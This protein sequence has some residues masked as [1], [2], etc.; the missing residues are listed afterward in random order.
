MCITQ[1]TLLKRYYQSPAPASFEHILIEMHIS[2]LGLLQTFHG[3]FS[4]VRKTQQMIDCMGF[5]GSIGGQSVSRRET[6][7]STGFHY[8]SNHRT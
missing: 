7:L 2:I 5:V 8:S 3:Q 4:L 6:P 1:N